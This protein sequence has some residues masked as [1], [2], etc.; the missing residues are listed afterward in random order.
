[1]LAAAGDSPPDIYLHM[2]D[3]AYNDGTTQEFDDNF[4]APYET[5]LRNTVVW[6]TLG[7]HE[8]HSSD[9][10]TETG[11]YYEAYVLPTDGAA[12]GLASGTEAYYSFDWAS[13][14]FIVLDSHD[15]PRDVGGAMLRWLEMDL[16]ATDQPWVIAFWHHPPYSK[17]SHDSDTETQLVEMRENALPILEAAG[18][19]LVLC[20]H[21][22][23]YE[24]S[25]LIHG[26]YDT[27][28]TSA[29]HILDMGDG[30]I[31]GDGAYTKTADGTLYVVAGHGGTSVSGTGGHPVM[32]FTEVEN[33]SCLVD[34]AGEALTLRNIRYDGEET[35]HVTLVKSNGL[36]LLAPVGGETFL[37]GSDVDVT[38]VSGPGTAAVKLE[39]SLDGGTTWNL[40]TDSTENDGLFVWTTPRR[41]TLEGRVRIS[42]VA[43]ESDTSASP[44]NFELSDRAES[45][46]VP[47][48]SVWE[49]HDRGVNQG[50]A[51]TTTYGE[52][53]SGPAQLGYG[54][55]DEA[56]VLRDDDPNIPTVYFRNQVDLDQVPNAATVDALFDDGVAVWING[57]RVLAENMDD[58]FGF[59]AWASA[60]SDDNQRITKELDLSTT[61]PF[62]VGPNIVAAMVKQ[63]D[64]TSSDLS[65]DLQLTVETRVALDTDGGV[66]I[67][68]G[69]PEGG[70][71]DGGLG[72]ASGD[73]GP[74]GKPDDPCGCHIPGSGGSF[75]PPWI[76]VIA[77]GFM[78]VR[79]RRPR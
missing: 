51:W 70:V 32:H 61:N 29:G 23:L 50:D 6:P 58:G 48:G 74:E 42:D 45:T 53:S 72:D 33:G 17:G 66:G 12:G 5:I 47:F 20:G 56:T 69:I 77:A 34:V 59:G 60:Q 19:D 30:A 10:D 18:V 79:R 13:V 27:P 44:A 21:S 36:V 57:E 37:A 73:A 25:Y 9:S 39:Y 22:H 68:G 15:S 65:F 41:T 35:D 76:L 2:G 28:T 55:G 1:M 4:F 78:A 64:E 7:N 14:H 67:D 63:A 43:D 62:T 26:A 24:R 11:P 3:M 40:I 38:W 49:Y 52:W 46:L 8:G 71:S 16:S 54:D 31:E 75:A